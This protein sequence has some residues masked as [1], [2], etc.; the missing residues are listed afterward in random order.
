[1]NFKKFKRL[2]SVALSASML[3]STNM[4]AL[5]AETTVPAPTNIAVEEENHEHNWQL[6]NVIKEA[7]ATEDGIGTY[8]CAECGTTKDGAIVSAADDIGDGNGSNAEAEH[9]HTL[10]KKDRVAP[11]CWEEG[12]I[13]Y[14]E[15]KECGKMFL[16]SSADDELTAEDIKID[17]LDHQAVISPAVPVS[18]MTV[19]YKEYYYCRRS[20]ERRVGKECL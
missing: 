10:E 9:S 6:D 11:T 16:T 15:C 20:E 12:T 4:T 13:S 2:L 1:M 19:G 5:A 17:K 14:W 8:S 3:L 18:C 7:T